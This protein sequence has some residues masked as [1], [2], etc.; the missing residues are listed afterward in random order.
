MNYKFDEERL[1]KEIKEYIDS[2]YKEHYAA[3]EK[4]QVTEFIMSH[5]DTPDFLRGNVLKYAARYGMKE[6]YNRKDILKSLHYCLLLLCYHDR[7]YDSKDTDGYDP[8][9]KEVFDP[10]KKW[11]ELELLE[12]A[13]A[14][15][16][17][18]DASDISE[19]D[20]EWFKRAKLVMPGLR[21][22]RD[23]VDD[24]D[25]IPKRV[26]DPLKKWN[27]AEPTPIGKMRWAATDEQG[28]KWTGG[29][30]GLWRKE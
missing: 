26:F 14:Q 28:N 23:P 24:Y 5:L 29:D 16:D 17:D 13:Q 18:I 30:R 25:P 8:I 6:G 3:G 20:E 11:K 9:P 7:K 19:V 4:I 21:R 15:K 2:T 27:P 1:L 12:L 10:L 22:W